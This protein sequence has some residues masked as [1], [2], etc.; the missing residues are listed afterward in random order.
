VI[1]AVHGGLLVVHAPVVV[2]LA[3][4]LLTCLRVG[5]DGLRG[6]PRMPAEA[7]AWSTLGLGGLALA[8]SA[9]DEWLTLLAC[10]VLGGLAVLHHRSRALGG[11]AA[12]AGG[13]VLGPLGALALWAVASLAEV[14][15]EWAALVVLLALGAWL[16]LR[17][18]ADPTDPADQPGRSAWVEPVVG[19]EVGTVLAAA[20][21]A[22]IGAEVLAP[23]A[24]ESSWVAVY[25]TVL[26]VIASV[27]SLTRPERR[28]IAGWTG[29]V[30]LTAASWVRLADIGVQEPEP[31]TLPSAVVLVVV[32][33]FHLRRHPSAGTLRAWSSGL[34]LAL[35]PSLLWVLADPVSLRALVL[36]LA[37]LGLVLLGTQRRWAAPFVWGSAAGTVLVLRMV[38]PV[39]LLVGPFLVFAVGGVL[40]LVVGATWE[41]RLKDAE[42]LRHYMDDLR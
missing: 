34:G 26:G 7:A 32:G 31:Y 37:C 3:V 15:G 30:L 28:R 21:T 18:L 4:M 16:V 8:L 27:V 19:V 6:H 9:Y 13:L 41:R 33:W 5:I 14:E 40:L 36:G 25:L 11:W 42:R 12:W 1:A 29:F 39:A 2:L 35:V 10:T 38:A 17:G 22:L 20:V 24:Q 23:A